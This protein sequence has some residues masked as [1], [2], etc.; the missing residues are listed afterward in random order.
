MQT[1]PSLSWLFGNDPTPGIISAWADWKGQ[2]LVWRRTDR[3]LTLERHTF[4]PWVYA[5]H[6]TDLQLSGVPFRMAEEERPEGIITVQALPGQEGSSMYLLQCTDGRTLRN[7]ILQGASKRLGRSVKHLA[8]LHDYYVMAPLEQYLMLSGRTYFKD[9]KFD[10]LH[11]MQIDLET[12]SL[13]PEDGHIFL[14]SVKDSQGFEAV[15]E[16]PDEKE[17]IG[18]LTRLIQDRNPDVLENHNLMGFDMPFLVRRAEKLGLKLLWGREGAPQ[19]VVALRYQDGTRYSVAGRE[20]IDTLDAVRRHQFVARDMP[21]QRLK[22]VARYF[23][24]AGPDRVYIAGEKIH[25]TYLT[26]PEQ[27]RHYALDDVREVSAISERL[28]QPA[29][30]LSQMAPRSFERVAYAGTATGI[31][32]PMLV[33]AYLQERRALPCAQHG[34]S[35]APHEGGA[36][37]LFQAGVARNVV[38]ADISSLYPSIMRQYQIGPACDELGVMTTLVDELT[39]RRLHHKEM[40][41]GSGEDAPYHNAIQAAMKLVINSAYGY[42]GA[43]K[44]ARFADRDAADRITSLGREI[45]HHVLEELQS[46]GMTLIEADT[47]GV[48]FSMPEHWTE[49]QGKALVQDISTTLPEMIHLDFEGWYPA[50]FSHQVKNYALLTRDDKLI[51]KGASLHSIRSEAFGSHF[52]RQALMALLHGDVEGVH[53]AFNETVEKLR[54]RAFKTREVTMRVR[55]TK[56]SQQYLHRRTERK[57]SPYEAMLHSGRESWSK[58]E[59]ILMYQAQGK[60]AR[61]LQDQDLR[62]YDVRHY[63]DALKKHYAERLSSAFSRED[64]DAVFPAQL[65]G[66]LFERSLTEVQIQYVAYGEDLQGS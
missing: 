24:V 9:M 3:G 12:T 26:D 53:Q 31:L 59:R 27:V 57:E 4:A 36:V 48:F 5:D 35:E 21:S 38:K 15:L 20:M 64:F 8:D 1:S 54:S 62:D 61:I 45:L 7:A 18:S 39:R 11:R 22:D 25:Q 49:A 51:L 14:I 34:V 66:R 23:G 2:A 52:L 40:A 30:A 55:L 32:E 60:G 19:E 44:M 46:R 41:K 16:H 29:F 17:L 28:M 47:D 13:S 43:G 56:S 58:G 50:M 10:D 6:L 42:L 37:Y 33:R 65:Q 63:I